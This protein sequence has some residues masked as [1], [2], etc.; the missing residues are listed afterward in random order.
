MEEK[1]SCLRRDL[2]QDF[3]FQYNNSSGVL[4]LEPYIFEEAVRSYLYK[5]M[6]NLSILR[7]V[8]IICSTLTLLKEK[9]HK[10]E[11][12][13]SLEPHNG[14]AH[15]KV[16]RQSC[17]PAQSRSEPYTVQAQACFT[18]NDESGPFHAIAAAS[19]ICHNVPKLDVIVD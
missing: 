17:R 8:H 14:K 15:S 9:Y 7:A 12:T 19:L 10:S 1:I 4:P 6:D 5:G 16:M 18:E 13:Q 2:F 3:I 11:N